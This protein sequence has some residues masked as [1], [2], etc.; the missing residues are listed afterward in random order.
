MLEWG[1]G[2]IKAKKMVDEES[3]SEV[4][5]EPSPRF[6]PFAAPLDGKL[7]VWGGATKDD[8]WKSEKFRSTIEI[9]DPD[10]NSWKAASTGGLMLPPLHSGSSGALKGHLYAYDGIND[11]CHS[12]KKYLYSLEV[13]S[14]SWRARLISDE[15]SNYNDWMGCKIVCYNDTI[16]LCGGRSKEDEDF[17]HKMFFRA[18]SVSSRKLCC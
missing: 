16:Y 9:F 15:D 14:L 17:Q 12:I 2:A 1:R 5:Y 4:L 8:S 11:K 13:S 18:F 3:A 7:Y 6:G 10:L